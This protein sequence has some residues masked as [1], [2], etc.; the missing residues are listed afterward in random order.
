[1]KNALRIT[2]PCSEKFESFAPTSNGGFCRLCAKEVIDFTNMPEPE[3]IA[4]FN[5][6]TTDTCGRFKSTQLKTYRT[7][8]MNRTN[9][10]FFAR[11]M[12][13]I[14]LSI[15]S[16]GN[17]TALHAQDYASTET[18]IQVSKKSLDTNG[19][20]LQEYTVKGT[21]LDE[22][23]EPL[24]GVNV[25]LKGTAEGVVTDLDGKFEF[26]RNLEVGNILVFSFLGYETKEY[27]VPESDSPVLDITITFDTVDVELMGAVDTGGVYKSKRNIFQKFLGLFK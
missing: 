8:A 10:G 2:Q 7:S 22:M 15:L 21:V 12:A 23:N 1:M 13:I 16:L 26:P 11:S 9:K 19:I 6:R 3:L 20:S 17:L 25:V 24:S 5:N 4:F 18:E 27:I 14:G